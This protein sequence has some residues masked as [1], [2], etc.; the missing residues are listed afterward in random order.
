[1]YGPEHIYIND[2]IVKCQIVVRILIIT[3][4]HCGLLYAVVDND[5]FQKIMIANL[6][7][8]VLNNS[9]L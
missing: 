1:M 3:V 5:K 4:Y 6:K 7:I 9:L 2:V 8:I